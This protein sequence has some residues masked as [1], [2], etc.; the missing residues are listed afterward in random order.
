MSMKI[1]NAML[2]DC[3]TTYV[4][5][6]ILADDTGKYIRVSELFGRDESGEKVLGATH[7]TIASK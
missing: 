3:S 4:S 2:G 6:D 1:L 7:Y 5:M